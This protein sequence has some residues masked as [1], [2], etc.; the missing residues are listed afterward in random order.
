VQ[1]GLPLS[2]SALRGGE[3]WGRVGRASAK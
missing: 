1:L 2:E 3:S